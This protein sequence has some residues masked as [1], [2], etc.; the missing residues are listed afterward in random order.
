MKLQN[1]RRK[2]NNNQGH[3][4]YTVIINTSLGATFMHHYSYICQVFPKLTHYLESL[5]TAFNLIASI[6]GIGSVKKVET[7]YIVEKVW[8]NRERR[9]RYSVWT[10]GGGRE[11]ERVGGT[12]SLSLSI[13]LSHSLRE[14]V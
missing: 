6:G 13:A 8:G 4:Y 7:C 11:W 9:W 14:I 5:D 2:Q 1:N 12:L 10:Q 3:G